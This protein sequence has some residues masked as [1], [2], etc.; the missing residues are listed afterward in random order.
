MN[1]NDA[2]LMLSMFR[3]IGC[4]LR[5]T[6]SAACALALITNSG[7][8]SELSENVY[9][10]LCEPG[11]PGVCTMMVDEQIQNYRISFELT[12]PNHF[13]AALLVPQC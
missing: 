12:K 8:N 4:F 10:E 5:V 3:V 2:L 9:I 11:E 1:P 13:N 6:L 7:S